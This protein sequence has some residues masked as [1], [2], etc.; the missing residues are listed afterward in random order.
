MI[1]DIYKGSQLATA[2]SISFELL[3]IL[4]II[5]ILTP[6]LIASHI[7]DNHFM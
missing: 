5:R 7:S 6:R 4:C 3:S 2:S 1:P